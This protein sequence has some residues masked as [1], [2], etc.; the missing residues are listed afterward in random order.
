[1]LTFE[2]LLAEAGIDP[3]ACAVL[4]HTAA[5]R[6]LNALLPSYALERRDLFNAYQSVQAPAPAR[7]LRGCTHL[8]AFIGQD[9]GRATFAG[10]WRIGVARTLPPD[11]IL[12][13]PHVADLVALG[14]TLAGADAPQETRFDLEQLAT[15][16]DWIGRLVVSW[17]VRGINWW[18][19]AHHHVFP[20]HA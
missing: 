14:M 3:A 16:E 13:L 4:R 8:A 15:F 5:D 9:K 20:V 1:M 18:L 10:L 17:P 6:R 19:R 12:A 7:M 11:E 2:R